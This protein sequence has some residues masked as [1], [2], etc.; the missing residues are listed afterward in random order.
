M[1]RRLI[2]LFIGLAALALV[3]CETPVASPVNT[4]TPAPTATPPPTPTPTPT[5]VPVSAPAAAV[6]AESMRVA[7][8]QAGSFHVDMEL[9]IAVSTQGLSL[10]I[11]FKFNGDFQAPDKTR[12]SVNA[13]VLGFALNTEFVKIGDRS[14]IKDPQTGQWQAGEGAE[15]IVPFSPDDFLGDEF[16]A[17]ADSPVTGLTLAGTETLD[18]TQVWHYTATISAD[19]LDVKGGDFKLDVYVGVA[20]QLPRKITMK[21]E[22]DLGSTMEGQE[23]SQVPLPTGPA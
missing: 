3:A 21:G 22:V 10:D 20:D 14:W 15:G 5:P 23:A 2:P 1:I 6:L 13:S 7:I 8:A 11:P 16:L 12:G 17:S 18:G 19:K 4:P 9:N